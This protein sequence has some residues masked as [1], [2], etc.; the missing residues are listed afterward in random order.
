VTAGRYLPCQNELTVTVVGRVYLEDDGTD[1]STG[2]GDAAEVEVE[3]RT[4]F[5][6]ISFW[7]YIGRTCFEDGDLLVAGRA[8]LM[9]LG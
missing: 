9:E 7:Y 3:V 8:A 6:L 2:Q 4:V 5:V 1:V